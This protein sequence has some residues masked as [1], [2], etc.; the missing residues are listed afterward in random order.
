MQC[1]L[2]GASHLRSPRCYFTTPTTSRLRNA[3]FFID[4]RRRRGHSATFHDFDSKQKGGLQNISHAKTIAFIS[5]GSTGN[6]AHGDTTSATKLRLLYQRKFLFIAV[7]T[8]YLNVL[9]R[10]LNRQEI[11]SLQKRLQDFRCLPHLNKKL[12]QKASTTC[13]Q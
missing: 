8:G 2:Q 1:L 12:Q 5:K 6:V 3:A 4:D 11:K 7:G 10:M 9:H 13:E